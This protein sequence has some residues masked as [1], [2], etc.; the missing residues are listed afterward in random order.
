MRIL[1]CRDEL[2]LAGEAFGGYALGEL[3]AQYLDH[4]VALQRAVS[5]EEDSRH[6]ASAE[7][8]LDQVRVAESG[9][10][11]VAEVGGHMGTCR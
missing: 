2:D 3:G 6:G 8:A 1:E 7:F 11:L 5:R 10:K 9:L 4:D